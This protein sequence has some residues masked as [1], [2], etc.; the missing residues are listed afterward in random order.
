MWVGVG[1]THRHTD[2]RTWSVSAVAGGLAGAAPLAAA[3]FC[4][5]K[6]L[7]PVSALGAALETDC[8]AAIVRGVSE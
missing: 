2:T 7:N 4:L 8:G 3:S 1:Q 5:R 6:L